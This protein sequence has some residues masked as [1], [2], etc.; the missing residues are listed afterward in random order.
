MGEGVSGG[1]AVV[2]CVYFAMCKSRLPLSNSKRV[3]FLCFRALILQVSFLLD[4]NGSLMV[5]CLT[6]CEPGVLRAI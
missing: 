6:G 4:H 1:I 3:L 5:L 2:V